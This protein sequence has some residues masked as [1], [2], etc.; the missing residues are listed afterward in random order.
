MNSLPQTK[1][2]NQVTVK[3]KLTDHNNTP[4]KNTDIQITINGK[5]YGDND[6]TNITKVTVKTNDN[7][8]YNY[9]YKPNSG[10]N[11]TITIR[12]SGDENYNAN[13][14]QTTLNVDP[15]DT[16]ITVNP[17]TN[18]HVNQKTNITGKLTD[19]NGN[20]LKQTSVGIIIDNNKIYVKTD[21]N[22][23]YTYEY[24]PTT[25][26]TKNIKIYYGGYHKYAYSITTLN[27]DVKT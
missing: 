20:P 1:A 9:T 12:K 5:L 19:E 26:G 2:D 27:L 13:Q 7:G 14:T 8:I 24:T 18:A 17:I 22:G 21:T 3:G 6:Y 4:V 25:T 23:K 16:N 11:Y 10:G 15:I